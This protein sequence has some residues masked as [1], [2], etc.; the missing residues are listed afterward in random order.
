MPKDQQRT[1]PTLGSIDVGDVAADP[2]SVD[3]EE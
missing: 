1:K 3:I 2:G